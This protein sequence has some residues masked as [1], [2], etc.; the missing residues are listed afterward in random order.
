[1]TI[2][3][4]IQYQIINQLF[5]GNGGRKYHTL[6]EYSE[7]ETVD[8]NNFGFYYFNRII[9]D[10]VAPSVILNY[11]LVSREWYKY[12]S[13]VLFN[14]FYQTIIFDEAEEDTL[15][16]LSK[17]YSMYRFDSVTILY[18]DFIGE[19]GT[20]DDNFQERMAELFNWVNK[21]RSLSRLVLNTG[22]LK[23]VAEIIKQYPTVKVEVNVEIGDDMNL[24]LNNDLLRTEFNN[25]EYVYFDASSVFGVLRQLEGED[26]MSFFEVIR[27]WRVNGFQFDYE[28]NEEGNL[29]KNRFEGIFKIQSLEN[30]VIINGAIDTSELIFLVKDN[31]HIQTF[32]SFLPFGLYDHKEPQTVE[33]EEVFQL[34]DC[35]VSNSL[36]PIEMNRTCSKNN[37]IEHWYE[38]CD[39]LATNKT[40][41][42]LNLQN[43]CEAKIF[44]THPPSKS[45]TINHASQ[46]FGSA[47]SINNT[48]TRLT[49]SG[50]VISNSFYDVLAQSNRSI[51]HLS[52]KGCPLSDHLGSITKMIQKKPLVKLSIV[53][54]DGLA[55]RDNDEFGQHWSD[56]CSTISTNKTITSLKIVGM[57]SNSLKITLKG[58]K[59][60]TIIQSQRFCSAISVNKWIQSLSISCN[61]ISDCKLFYQVLSSSDRNQSIKHLHLK[62]CDLSHL[63]AVSEMLLLNKSITRMKIHSFVDERLFLLY[64]YDEVLCEHKKQEFGERVSKT[65]KSFAKSLEIHQLA[66][67]TLV[68]DHFTEQFMK[69]LDK[70]SKIKNII[71]MCSH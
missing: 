20:P 68:R 43:M 31:T 45:G 63:Q 61:L 64:F 33:E 30:I 38:F 60:M 48:L 22:S 50:Q 24:G 49:I 16:D 53:Y 14:R 11:A 21:F 67:L 36:D 2:N 52:I 70:D 17:E 9:F 7:S 55:D 10:L 39:S 54:N 5:K 59:P 19:C 27:Q 37:K 34:C 57:I 62:D 13:G 32:K 46:S 56:F 58:Q 29:L 69:S 3:K 18:L 12:I 6:R 51:S 28:D 47:L 35:L 23:L 66:K 4:L 26:N 65:N 42:V 40:L 15:V 8:Q 41:R 1:M 71:E 25:L 44:S